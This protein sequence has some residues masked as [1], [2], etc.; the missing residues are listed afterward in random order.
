MSTGL[1]SGVS[2]LAL[3]SGL[4]R[5]V[6][7][8]WSGASGLIAGFD[9]GGGGGTTPTLV[10]NLL[11]PALDSRVTFSRA[12]TATYFN[13]A[14]VITLAAVNEPRFDYMPRTL[15]ERGLLLEGTRTNEL[16]NSLIDGTSLSTQSVAVTAQA[17][18]ISFYG[19]GQIVLSGAASATVTG[20]GAFPTRTTY[21]FTPSA[22]SLTV[23]VTGTVQYAQLEAGD[24]AS[25]FIPTAGAA[26]T[27]AADSAA[28]TGT[29]FSSWYTPTSGTIVLSAETMFGTTAT[30]PSALLFRGTSD[31]QA[32]YVNA[33]S[34]AIGYAISGHLTLNFLTQVYTSAAISSPVSLTSST[35]NQFVVYGQA[36]AYATNDF[37]DSGNG[38]TPSTTTS[39]ETATG[40]TT[41]VLGPTDNTYGYGGWF[42]W[43]RGV[44]AY[45]SR[46]GNTTLADL[47]NSA[48]I[49]PATL[50]MNF[51]SGSYMV[52]PLT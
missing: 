50:V 45:G 3:G 48:A 10:L 44:T 20:T 11:Y 7:G 25:S 43:L 41:M 32:L 34:R 1:Y 14:G 9:G 36:V 38:A 23:T 31:Y 40:L 4:Y 28:M 26:A 12:S 51:L 16:L 6:S 37:A 15:L 49:S 46:L 29:N 5:N 30:T 13:S 24:F 52:R 22:G 33:T 39:G 19:T 47:S 35:A 27:R 2:G 18:T 8:L 21:T 17:Y 42:G